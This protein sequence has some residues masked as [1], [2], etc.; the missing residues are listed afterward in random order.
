MELAI[1]GAISLLCGI[2][3][4]LGVGGG[5]LFLIYL[6]QFA[7][8]PQREAQLVNL[9]VFIPT[10]V[11]AVRLHRKNGFVQKKTGL[12]TALF[13]LIGVACG[14]SL[15]CILEP[16]LLKKLFGV[17]LAAIGLWELFRK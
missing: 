2:L 14:L 1:G 3:S 13:G 12:Y 4:A 11:C 6:I 8:F 15:G 10:A 5:G 16:G 7:A 9:L 17:F